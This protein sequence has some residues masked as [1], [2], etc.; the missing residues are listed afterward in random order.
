MAG[1]GGEAARQ[2][3]GEALGDVE[4]CVGNATGKAVVGVADLDH[5]D[6]STPGHG[7]NG[8]KSARRPD[9]GE[10]LRRVARKLART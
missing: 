4:G 7:R 3:R 5:R 6:A 9:N 10:T 2:V 8:D 1:S